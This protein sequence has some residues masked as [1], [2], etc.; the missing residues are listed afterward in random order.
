MPRL[1]TLDIDETGWRSLLAEGLD[2]HFLVLPPAATQF[3]AGKGERWLL[4]VRQ[5]SDAGRR[6]WEQLDE[7]AQRGGH[8][9]LDAS[10]LSALPVSLG[11]QRPVALESSRRWR[12]GAWSGR[13]PSVNCSTL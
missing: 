11:G 6:R 8:H 12:W 3:G 2:A 1:L 13:L 5:H 10:A 7:A 4:A 9:L